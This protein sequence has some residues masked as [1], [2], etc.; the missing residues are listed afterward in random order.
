[1]SKK[2]ALLIPLLFLV[3][4]AKAESPFIETGA[5][6]PLEKNAHEYR[7][8][9][10]DRLWHIRHGDAVTKA[11][12]DLYVID[13]LIGDKT[14]EE[15]LAD[16]SFYSIDGNGDIYLRGYQLTGWYIRWLE[17]PELVLKERMELSKSYLVSETATK[18]RRTSITISLKKVGDLKLKNAVMPCIVV[19]KIT[20]V[21]QIFGRRVDYTYE[22]RFYAKDIGLIKHTGTCGNGRCAAMA[23]SRNGLY[24]Q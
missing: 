15:K 22:Q 12:I 1:M 2:L 11:S 18:E 4:T 24:L 6:F 3:A 19:E 9:D 14:G 10:G 8:K 21:E 20:R 17:G 7:L 5:Y 16:K 13:T 23:P